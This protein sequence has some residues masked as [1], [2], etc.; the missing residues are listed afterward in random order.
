MRR[1]LSALLAIL[2][3]GTAGCGKKETGTTAGRP[4]AA[5]IP[6]GTT[7]EFWKAI[8]AGALK[9]G[10]EAGIEIIWKGPLKEDDR[11]AQIS[12]VEDFISR[13]VSGI[14]LAPLD[15]AALRSPV[16]GAMHAGIPVIIIDSDLQGNEYVS[17]VA[18]DNFLGG[19]LAG[20][21]MIEL[22]GGKGRVVL[23]RYQEGSA[24]TAKREAGFLEAIAAAPGI[25]VVSASQFGGATTETAYKASEN[26]LAPLREAGGKLT[27]DGIFTPNE[28]TTFGMLRALQ[29]AGL[30]GSVVFLGFDSS[31]KLIEALGK[32]ELN[33]LVLQNPF[34]MGYLGV[35]TLADHLKGGKVDQ[36]IDTGV[37][38]ATRENMNQAEIQ[39]LL[40]PDLSHWLK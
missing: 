8:H 26:L 37:T 24:S 18:T 29:D 31:A 14:V 11:E 7:H 5:V 25:T 23:L 22:L 15:D 19:Q 21:K 32:G 6:K 30:A 9:A 1:A 28:S 40:R 12:V 10:D 33:G 35:K 13:K 17:F 34:R 4:V 20:K 27:V 36:K 2:A 38:L 39:E 3:L 16:S